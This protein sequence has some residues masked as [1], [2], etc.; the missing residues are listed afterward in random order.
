MSCKHFYNLY[1]IAT[2]V[3][4]C[5]CLTCLLT[6][7]MRKTTLLGFSIFSQQVLITSNSGLQCLK[8]SQICSMLFS[9][10]GSHCLTS[11]F[12]F[13][14]Q[15]WFTPHAV[16]LHQTTIPAQFHHMDKAKMPCLLCA[17]F[18]SLFWGNVWVRSTEKKY[19]MQYFLSVQCSAASHCSATSHCLTLH[20][21]KLNL[22]KYMCVTSQ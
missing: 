18:A 9:P 22:M 5:S 8:T 15:G 14:S 20:S 3:Y 4:C 10:T 2:T 1:S 7:L 16:G 21:W 6:G 19:C 11:H 12:N 17:Q 13:H